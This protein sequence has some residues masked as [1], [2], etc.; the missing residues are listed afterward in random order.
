MKRENSRSSF[1]SP[2]LLPLFSS[3][4]PTLISH[5]PFPPPLP[6]FLSP[7]PECQRPI[8]FQSP[9]LLRHRTRKCFPHTVRGIGR[10]AVHFDSFSFVLVFLAHTHARNHSL[11]HTHAFT[12]PPTHARTTNTRTH[13]LTHSLTH[14]HVFTHTHTLTHTHVFTHT[15]THSH[16]HTLTHS[17]THS[18][19]PTLFRVQ[20]LRTGRA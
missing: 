20:R 1:A 3:S 17:L 9:Q 6:V 15:N 19:V 14:S 18:L 11:T 8:S 10:G 2:H 16:T 5:L 4:L 7:Q 13:S 12:H